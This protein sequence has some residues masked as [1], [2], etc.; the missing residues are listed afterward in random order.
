M[1]PRQIS[2][3]NIL[4]SAWQCLCFLR[5]VMLT[6]LS[7]LVLTSAM[8]HPDWCDLVPLSSQRQV[9]QWSLAESMGTVRDFNGYR[10]P[11]SS[12]HLCNHDSWVSTFE[13]FPTSPIVFPEISKGD[14]IHMCVRSHVDISFVPWQLLEVGSWAKA[15][16]MSILQWSLAPSVRVGASGSRVHPGEQPPIAATATTCTLS[17]TRTTGQPVHCSIKTD[18][19]MPAAGCQGPFRHKKKAFSCSKFSVELGTIEIQN[20]VW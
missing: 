13:T 19:R 14:C 6:L 3:S 2:G 7:A 20:F 15:R 5:D 1:L 8:G 17:I 4:Y 18:A 12:D 11:Q 16:A 10:A 9:S